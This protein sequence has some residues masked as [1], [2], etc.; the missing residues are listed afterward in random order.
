MGKVKVVDAKQ[1]V[2]SIKKKVPGVDIRKIVSNSEIIRRHEILSLTNLKKTSVVVGDTWSTE[3]TP[4]QKILSSRI[5]EKVYKLDEIKSSNDGKIAYVSMNATPAGSSEANPVSMMA[6]MTPGLSMD[7]EDSYSGSM[8]FDVDSGTVLTHSQVLK[9][10]TIA[11]DTRAKD[12]EP[13]VL[14]IT[15]TF[16]DNAEI[17]K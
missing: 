16:I 15:Q 14:I 11:T 4:S 13:D 3:E 9:V 8:T 2:A 6:G 5:F 10:A 12:K 17:I 1:A 7:S